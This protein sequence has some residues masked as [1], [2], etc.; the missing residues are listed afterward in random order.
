MNHRF[1][2]T[3]ALSLFILHGLGCSDSK[4]VV[5]SRADSAISTGGSSPLSDAV[6]YAKTELK[7][8]KYVEA[9]RV[10]GDTGGD[11][12]SQK[13]NLDTTRKIIYNASISLIV[14]TMEESE[15]KLRELIDQHQ[16]RVASSESAGTSG[17][18]RSG[19]WKIRIPVDKFDAFKLAVEKIGN[20]ERSSLDSKDVTEE[21]YDVEAR[22]KNKQVEEKRLI[23][24]LE[25]TTGKLSDILEVEKELSRVRGEIEQ[26]QGRLNLLQNLTSLTTVDV[27]IRE[28]KNYV[29]P[30]APTFGDEAERTLNSSWSGFVR[31]GKNLTLNIISILPWLPIW[32]IVGVILY[33][34]VRRLAKSAKSRAT[35]PHAM[36]A[37]A[38]A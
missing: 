29:P 38:T 3:L 13:A 17:A 35:V 36:E 2:V 20:L 5:F 37:A 11:G 4:E 6:W 12:Q 28:V 8:A 34:A 24:H 16:G 18:Q 22:I 27:F 25:K 7:N 30:T 33:V 15:K 19:R 32:I 10:S 1:S 21:F 14:E 9:L 23:Q 31:T 26:M